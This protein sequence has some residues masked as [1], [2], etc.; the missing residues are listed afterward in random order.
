MKRILTVGVFD[1]FHYGHLKLFEQAK[2]IVSDGFLIVAVQKS[3]FIKNIN[4]R[5][6]FFIQLMFDVNWL[7]HYVA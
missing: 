6:M 5:R 2:N 1:Y 3:E 4:Q 7:G